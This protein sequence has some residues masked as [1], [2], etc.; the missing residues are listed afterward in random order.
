[1]WKSNKRDTEKLT[2]FNTITC[3]MDRQNNAGMIL[4]DG[5]KGDSYR[6]LTAR[7]AYLLMGFSEDDYERVKQLNLSYRKMIKLA[8]NSIVVP[9]LEAIFKAMLE[10]DICKK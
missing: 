4:Y 7:E 2:Y 1:M 8:G 5:P 9:V 6:L 3:N 10:E